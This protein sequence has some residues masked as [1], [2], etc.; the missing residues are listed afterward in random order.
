MKYLKRIG[1]IVILLGIL[2]F[3]FEVYYLS[4]ARST[5]GVIKEILARESSGPEYT[6]VRE[7]S[8]APCKLKIQFTRDGHE[9]VFETVGEIDPCSNFLQSGNYYKVD[10]SVEVKYDPYNPQNARLNSLSDIWGGTLL[11]IG[12]GIFL[13]GLGYVIE[14]FRNKNLKKV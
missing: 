11:F 4:K 3:I 1:I 6:S 13:Y 14:Q 8:Q 7:G 5:T 12:G 9:I 2:P 10:Q